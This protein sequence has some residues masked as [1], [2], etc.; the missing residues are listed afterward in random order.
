MWVPEFGRD[1][2]RFQF[3]LVRVRRGDSEAEIHALSNE[4]IPG[5]RLV[6]V[7]QVLDAIKFLPIK[8]DAGRVAV[9]IVLVNDIGRDLDDLVV[10]RSK[11]SIREGIGLA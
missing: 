11:K 6:N 10:D 3:R 1:H 4:E 9:C 7:G 5:S 8:G 2:N